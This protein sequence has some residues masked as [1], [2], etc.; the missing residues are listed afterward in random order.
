MRRSIDDHPFDP[1]DHPPGAEDADLAPLSWAVAITDDYDDARPR[2]VLTV[3]EAGRPGAG[4]VAHL[5]PANAR[6][7]RTALR[8]AL[9]E[10]GEEPGP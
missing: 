1:A 10:L 6:R 2:V 7:L 4:L 3:E 9:R 8:D 5:P